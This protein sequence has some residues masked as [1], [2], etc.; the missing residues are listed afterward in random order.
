MYKVA[1]EKKANKIVYT[2]KTFRY[3]GF[4]FLKK[5]KENTKGNNSDR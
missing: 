1:V 3:L 2:K 4:I 5:N